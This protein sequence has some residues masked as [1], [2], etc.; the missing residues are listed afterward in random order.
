MTLGTALVSLAHA[1]WQ[2]IALY[3]VVAA[4]G[5]T[6]CGILPVSIHVSRWFPAERGFVSAVAACGFSLGHLAFT[7]LAAR[8][9]DV[10]GWRETY[11]PAGRRAGGHPR[12]PWSSRSATRP[13][14]RPS[15]PRRY[16]A[17]PRRSLDPRSR[18]STAGPPSGRRPSGR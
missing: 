2:F 18:P 7:Q 8:A 15:G 1:P 3:G 11:L 4:V 13:P 5:Y 9:A 16:F 14:R 12:P 6:G 17:A 10:V